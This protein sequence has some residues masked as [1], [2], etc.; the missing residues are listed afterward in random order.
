MPTLPAPRIVLNFSVSDPTAAG[1]VQGDVLVGAALGVHP[2]TV[3]TGLTVRD[4]SRT[5]AAMAV[6]GDWIADQARALLE[7]IPV[8]AFKVGALPGAESVAEV[9]EVLTDYP[10][11]PVV[12][13]PVLPAFADQMDEEEMIGALCELL[14]PA[15][16]VLVV[17]H[18]LAL[19]LAADEDELQE[20]EVGE[21]ECARRLVEFGAAHVLI[22]GNHRPGPQ[23]V[24][25]LYGSA[26]VLRTDAW[27][28]LPGVAPAASDLLAAAMAAFLAQGMA[29][30]AAAHAAQAYAWQA[31]AQG[32]RLG[33]GHSIPNRSC[34][35]TRP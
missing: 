35:W 22:T 3:V 11:V 9:A 15:T 17:D 24:N 27:E 14:V 6:E 1:G 8:H 29:P 4:S 23:V 18:E 32:W 10:A 13:C 12:A 31:V 2:L 20:T 25:T 30:Q 19:R 26:G 7:D 16:T 21:A 5:E 33:M 28:R 34:A